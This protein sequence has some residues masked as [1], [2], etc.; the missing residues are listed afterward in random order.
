MKRRYLDILKGLEDKPV[1]EQRVNSKVLL[2]DGLNAFIRAFA[3]NPTITDDGIHVGGIVGFLH[4]IGYAIRVI[5][6]TRVI[7]AFDG[8]GG[9]VR[10]KQIFPEYKANRHT[11]TRISR[12]DHFGSYEEENEAKNYQIKKLIEYLQYLPV[13]YILARDIEADDAIAYLSNEMFDKSECVIM[14]TDQDYLQLVDDR[15]TVWSP[16][17]KKMYNVDTLTEEFGIT[18]NNFLMYKMLVGDTSD[19][20]PGIKGIGLKSIIKRFP[21]LCETEE[22]TIDKL[23]NYSN[24]QLSILDEKGKQVN[25]YK[26]YK[27]VLGCKD[28]LVLNNDLIQLKEVD[29]TRNTKI[30][31]SNQIKRPISRLLKHQF[32]R[33]VLED[34]MNAGLKNP[35]LWLRENF[36]QLDAFASETHD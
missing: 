14:S 15:I 6:P 17:K 12:M 28:Q 10:R 30:L 36:T 25:N 20:I 9:S 21:I 22:V 18:P 24:K 19:G 34:K 23:L 5:R 27:D 32:L 33:L 35:D 2:V 1:I 31:I 26:I 8:P 16:T 7:I 11:P 13:Q 3:V 4:T 29:I